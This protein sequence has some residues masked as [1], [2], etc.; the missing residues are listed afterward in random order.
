MCL[1][2]PIRE[3]RCAELEVGPITVLIRG[4]LER[5][6]LDRI[7]S[8]SLGGC[9]LFLR[10]N[11]VAADCLRVHRFAK[12]PTLRRPTSSTERVDTAATWGGGIPA[13]LSRHLRRTDGAPPRLPRGRHSRHFQ[14]LH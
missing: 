5:A 2:T 9:T 7:G 1:S 8:S 4:G 13:A 10:G 3:V 12:S 11:V 6:D 14:M